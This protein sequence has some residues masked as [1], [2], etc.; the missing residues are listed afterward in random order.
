MAIDA[1]TQLNLSVRCF[2]GRNVCVTESASAT[3]STFKRSLQRLTGIHTAT[4]R[5]IFAGA[6]LKDEVTLG[7]TALVDGA[8]IFMV[9]LK[10]FPATL[11]PFRAAHT[12]LSHRDFDLPPLEHGDFDAQGT[13]W[14]ME[15]RA[16]TRHGMR[17]SNVEFPLCGQF[18]PPHPV[19]LT[20]EEKAAIGIPAAA[21]EFVF[22]YPVVSWDAMTGGSDEARSFLAVGGYAYLD[23]E[24]KII[25]TTTLLPTSRDAGG[26]QFKGN[27]TW[28]PE[29][30]AA[31]MRQGRFQK[32]TIAALN[33]IGAHH[34]CWLRPGEVITG[35]DGE[36]CAQQPSVPHGGFAYLFHHEVFRATDEEL[37]LDRYF[38]IASGDDYVAADAA[39]ADGGR[40]DAEGGHAA[41]FETVSNLSELQDLVEA[42][43]A[44]TSA[45]GSAAGGGDAEH[46]R[47]RIAGLERQLDSVTKCVA[48]LTEDKDTILNPCRHLCMCAACAGRVN[49]CP[50]CRTSVASRQRS[51]IS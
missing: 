6:T 15:Q 36:P 45:P 9:A 41:A 10:V 44:A 12:G 17:G 5:L 26:L 48:C 30:T 32:I 29:W 20:N 13:M 49:R 42:A 39:D 50:I 22:S 47:T 14:I 51:Y 3:V 8:L 23:A 1:G 31:L 2:D 4:Q 35:D 28:R 43:A 18:S 27:R 40:E 38:P 21:H 11:G 33:R 24:R 37:A 7:S 25:H 34:F 16:A 19:T 46:L